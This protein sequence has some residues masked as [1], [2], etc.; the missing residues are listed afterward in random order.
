MIAALLLAAIGWAGLFLLVNIA[1]PTI[2]PRW[3]FFAFLTTA[4]TGTALPFVWLLHRRFN[5]G[6]PSPSA[7]L[8]RQGLLVG[9]YVSLCTWLQINR[10]L[11]L[12]LAIALAFGFLAIEGLIRLVEGSRWRPKS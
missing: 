4:A 1:L 9:L 3:L 11:S 10:S 8:L 5:H 7:A 2:G 6:P 12:G